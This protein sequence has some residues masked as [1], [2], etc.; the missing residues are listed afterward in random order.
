[1]APVEE[2]LDAWWQIVA[3][4]R[5]NRIAHRRLS[6]ERFVL[7]DGRVT[8]TEFARAEIGAGPGL[9]ANDVAELLV[10]TARRVGPAAAVGAAVD[11]LGPEAVSD[12]LPRLQP[13]AFSRATRR[14]AKEGDL[15]QPTA[16]VLMPFVDGEL[17]TW[18][19]VQ[20]A[21]VTVIGVLVWIYQPHA[22]AAVQ[23][24]ER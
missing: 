9:L 16:L 15:D 7:D 10:V 21:L 13:R 4:L 14:D 1:M 6:P 12:A 11:A 3:R 8:I 24:T 23:V 2:W 5:E 17:A 22:K 20:L 18:S 19:L